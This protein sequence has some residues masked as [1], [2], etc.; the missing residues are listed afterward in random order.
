MTPILRW[1]LTIALIGFVVWAS[2]ARAERDGAP[3]AMTVMTIGLVILAVA[4]A[5]RFIKPRP[6]AD[7]PPEPPRS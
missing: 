5:M 4:F 6:R 3:W 7:E 1:R 2:G